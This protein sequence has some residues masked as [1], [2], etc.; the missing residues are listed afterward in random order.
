MSRLHLRDISRAECGDRPG[1]RAARAVRLDPAPS[2]VRSIALLAQSI[3][4]FATFTH[5]KLDKI[6]ASYH[7]KIYAF[8]Q[9]DTLA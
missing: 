9:F 6:Y 7:F 5:Y 3:T 8:Y 1:K 4:H 2:S